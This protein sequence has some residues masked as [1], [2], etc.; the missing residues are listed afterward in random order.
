MV[1]E[2]IL[3]FNSMASDNLLVPKYLPPDII[4]AGR[5]IFFTIPNPWPLDTACGGCQSRMCG[6]FS[7][8]LGGCVGYYG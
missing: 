3:V 8:K 5:G 7:G 2:G 6:L 4:D 1:G